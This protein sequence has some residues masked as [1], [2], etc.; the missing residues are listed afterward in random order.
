MSKL[1]RLR[2]YQNPKDHFFLVAGKRTGGSK[3]GRTE[4]DTDRATDGVSKALQSS[5]AVVSSEAAVFS[6]VPTTARALPSRA[7]WLRNAGDTT[8]VS[9][10]Q[11]STSSSLLPPGSKPSSMPSDGRGELLEDDA[12]FMDGLFLPTMPFQTGEESKSA[13]RL[14]L[15][16]FRCS[17]VP[18]PANN[19]VLYN[20]AQQKEWD[21][22]EA[23]FIKNGNYCAKTCERCVN[24]PEDLTDFEDDEEIVIDGLDDTLASTLGPGSH[25]EMDEEDVDDAIIAGVDFDG[26]ADNVL[27]E[28]AELGFFSAFDDS[29]FAALAA[30][31]D[32]VQ[33]ARVRS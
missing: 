16:R 24:I 12:G 23:W 5:S 21:K 6:S 9:L 33:P 29:D 8:I 20:C 11:M 13:N 30:S 7:S 26:R 22:C 28:L 4:A 15:K 14:T 19:G 25:N 3:Y 31:M 1:E 32:A 18:P 2:S 27:A 10:P 17:D